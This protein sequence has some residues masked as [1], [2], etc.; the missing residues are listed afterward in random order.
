VSLE[1]VDEIFQIIRAEVNELEGYAIQ[2]RYPGQTADKNDAKAAYG[3]ALL[4]REFVRDQ[5][6]K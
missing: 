6:N 2:F 1:P 4:I 3:A 5:L